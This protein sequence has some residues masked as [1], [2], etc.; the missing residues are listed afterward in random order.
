[1]VPARVGGGGAFVDVVTRV[2][3]PRAMG[4][5]PFEVGA[6]GQGAHRARCSPALGTDTAKK[7]ILDLNS[8]LSIVI[9]YYL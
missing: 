1:M 4:T 8:L 9:K 5:E 3:E 2:G 6:S 7:H